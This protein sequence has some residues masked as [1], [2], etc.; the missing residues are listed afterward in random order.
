M[1]KR[2]QIRF[3]TVSLQTEIRVLTIKRDRTSE[4]DK[5]IR[6]VI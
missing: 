5:K 6:K 3:V 2:E 1:Q 4:T